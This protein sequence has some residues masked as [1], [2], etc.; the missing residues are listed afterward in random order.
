MYDDSFFQFNYEGIDSFGVS[1]VRFA[2]FQNPQL[3]ISYMDYLKLLQEKSYIDEDE[4]LEQLGV[5]YYEEYS[6]YLNE[7]QVNT[8]NTSIRFDTESESHLPL[9]HSTCHFHFGHVTNVR[10][11][12]KKIISP[13]G[14]IL[15]VLK[16]IYYGDWKILIEDKDENLLSASGAQKNG[17]I[18]ISELN[19]E[20][21]LENEELEIFM[22]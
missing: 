6:Q 5:A 3:Y 2:F 16:H 21:W 20:K 18:D 14:F 12:C 22:N 17:F 19:N 15:F 4:D 11:P 9:I 10:V 7:Q 8:S 1:V 13:L